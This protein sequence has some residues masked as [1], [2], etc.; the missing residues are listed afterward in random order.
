MQVCL[1]VP[2]IVY[3]NVFSETAG[4]T[5]T[6]VF[7]PSGPGVFRVSVV[8]YT[9]GPSVIVTGTISNGHVDDNDINFQG[10]SG[11]VPVIQRSQAGGG[12][13]TGFSGVDFLLST[14]VSGSLTSYEVYVT[15]EQLQ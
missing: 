10:S 1:N 2:S 8:I 5:D 9:T 6:V 15:I 4:V 11:G 14:S 7:S 12:V 3:Q 13:F